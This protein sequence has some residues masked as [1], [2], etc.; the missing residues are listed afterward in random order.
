MRRRSRQVLVGLGICLF[1]FAVT[2]F[3]QGRPPGGGP[4]GGGPPGGGPPGG[5]P[6]PG[7]PR[8]PAPEI[9]VSAAA[10]ALTVAA[11]A[12]MLLAERLRRP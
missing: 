9:D 1:C 4:P 10:G 2:A 11:G 6:P 3:A 7:V 8:V 12:L 5:G